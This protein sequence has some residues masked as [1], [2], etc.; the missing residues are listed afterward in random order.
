MAER[1]VG[2]AP[3]AATDAAKRLA[4]LQARQRRYT[5][6]LEQLTDAATFAGNGLGPRDDARSPGLLRRFLN[7]PPDHTDVSTLHGTDAATLAVTVEQQIRE[8]VQQLTETLAAMRADAAQVEVDLAKYDSFGGNAAPSSHARPALSHP[9]TGERFL[10]EQ[11]LRDEHAAI[12]AALQAKLTALR[13]ETQSSGRSS[14]SS[15]SYAQFA[16]PPSI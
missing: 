15:L 14:A 9:K 12:A 4:V 7:S 8:T 6:E 13:E 1:R 5:A 2:P 10:S 3:A 16:P 11:V